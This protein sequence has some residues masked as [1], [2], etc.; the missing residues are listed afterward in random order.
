MPDQEKGE[1]YW[2]TFERMRETIRDFEKDYPK[3][4]KYCEFARQDIF[5]LQ[6][7]LERQ[8]KQPCK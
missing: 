8:F 5:V 3:H 2:D 1:K 7:L 4:G 6:K